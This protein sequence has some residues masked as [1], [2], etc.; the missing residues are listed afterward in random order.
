[1]ISKITVDRNQILEMLKAEK[2][3]MADKLN[4]INELYDSI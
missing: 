3:K 2:M 4:E 1:M